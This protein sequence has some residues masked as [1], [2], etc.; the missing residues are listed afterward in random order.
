MDE[1][2]GTN[3]SVFSKLL[4]P[5]LHTNPFGTNLSGARAY[6]RAERIV[7]GV[8]LLTNHLS[9]EDELYRSTRKVSLAL[10][11]ILLDLKDEMRS[12]TSSKM[13]EFHGALRH[14]ISLLKMLVFSGSVSVQNADAVTN[15]LEELNTFVIAS[16]RSNLSESLQLSKEDFADP[17]VPYKGHLK[18]IRDRTRIRDI[19]SIK[20]MTTTSTAQTLASDDPNVLGTRG[21]AIVNILKVGGEL[22]LPDIAAHLPEYGEKTIQRELTALIDRGVVRRV[23]LKRWSKYSLTSIEGRFSRV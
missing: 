9:R 11:P 12:L 5:A 2:K 23:G 4:D 7:A 8:I 3:Q 17:R 1:L 20:D 21:A 16:A 13:R 10:L 22:N 18:D 19:K 6:R 15:A 14:L